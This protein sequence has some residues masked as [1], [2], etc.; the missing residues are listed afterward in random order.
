MSNILEQQTV[1]QT[2]DTVLQTLESDASQ[3]LINLECGRQIEIISLEGRREFSINN[4]KD[5]T[6]ITLTEKQVQELLS[7]NPE[8]IEAMEAVN[9]HFN[10][11]VTAPIHDRNFEDTVET[12]PSFTKLLDEELR[13]LSTQ[14]T[15]LETPKEKNKLLKQLQ[16]KYPNIDWSK[17]EPTANFLVDKFG[18]KEE[19]VNW[20]RPALIATSAVIIFISAVNIPKIFNNPEA[21][22][23]SGEVVITTG[24]QMPELNARLTSD[25][26]MDRLHPTLRIK[27]PHK[28]QDLGSNEAG[29][30]FVRSPVSG[31]IINICTG[32]RDECGGGYG[33]I[34]EV[35][36]VDING[37]FTGRTFRQAHM[38]QLN[39]KDDKMKAPKIGDFVEQGQII[40]VESDA[41]GLSSGNHTHIEVIARGDDYIVIREKR[42]G[43][44]KFVKLRGTS[45]E[46]GQKIR[47]GNNGKTKYVVRSNI[48]GN[49]NI[50]LKN[51]V[52]DSTKF[53]RFGETL[54]RPNDYSAKSVKYTNSKTLT[55]TK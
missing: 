26:N 52:P 36:E 21:G 39:Q 54:D 24:V 5:K 15:V 19:G 35:A 1:L 33:Q 18:D 23:K 51:P 43:Q 22:I 40:A 38:R 2:Q 20:N 12:V 45:A 9:S 44:T 6:S 31:R 4:P 29:K 10:S 53:S 48:V 28:G 42:T 14:P 41:G 11:Q 8:L 49:L 13:Q 37:N 32:N 25:M 46:M 27:R 50:K 16:Q 17:L 30:N 34:M 55:K 7:A 47:E 3:I